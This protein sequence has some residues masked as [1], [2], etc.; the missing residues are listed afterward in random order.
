MNSDN[1][2]VELPLSAST[3]GIVFCWISPEVI[4]QLCNLQLQFVSLFVVVVDAFNQIISLRRP[5]LRLLSYYDLTALYRGFI[6]GL[7]NH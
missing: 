3:P 7:F 1:M 2:C 5:E 6:S 4:F